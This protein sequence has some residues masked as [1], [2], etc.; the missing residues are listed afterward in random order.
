[1]KQNVS[2]AAA[3]AIIAVVVVI[4]GLLGWKTMSKTRAS[5]TISRTEME[6]HMKQ[7]MGS[8]AP[9][10]SGGANRP[11]GMGSP[12][13]NTSAGSGGMGAGSGSY[14]AG[15]GGYNGMSGSPNH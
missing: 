6:Q 11:G 8:G 7:S 13:H 5:A 12:D 14:G 2:P 1:M 4:V 3:A 15:S 9:P 10:G